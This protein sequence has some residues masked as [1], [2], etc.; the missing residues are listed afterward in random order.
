ME[1]VSRGHAMDRNRRQ[2]PSKW[3]LAAQILAER[4]A[5]QERLA[6][7]DRRGA[8]GN[9]DSLSGDNTRTSEVM[10]GV[11]ESVMKRLESASREVLISRLRALT[12]AEEKIREGTYGRC[13]SCGKPIPGARLRAMPEAVRCVPCAE[14]KS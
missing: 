10:E 8:I 14:E 4:R 12:R 3:T 13:D 6:S 7:L 9:L 11:Q 1:G 5:I 2:T